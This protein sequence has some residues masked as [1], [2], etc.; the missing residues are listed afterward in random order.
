MAI[1]EILKEPD[2]RL[3]R[4]SKPV[5]Q[6]GEEERKI[7]QDMVDT[8]QFAEGL[9]LAAPQVN[10]L[11]RIIVIDMRGIEKF[12]DYGILK[13]INPVLIYRSEA[14]EPMEEGCLSVEEYAC[15]VDRHVE[16]EVEYLDEN[17]LK[18]SLKAT[19]KLAHAL[20]HEIDHLDGILF[21]QRLSKLKYTRAIK[22]LTKIKNREQEI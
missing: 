20:Q 12:K 19:E 15:A 17:G 11:K 9:G 3:H 7:L 2:P 18:K 8:M 16:V 4:K 5:H 14:V 6:V 22:R 13:M 1:L 10:I 21:I